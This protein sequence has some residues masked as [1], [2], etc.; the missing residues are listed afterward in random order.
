MNI[1]DILA[2]IEDLTAKGVYLIVA[3]FG[4]V[5][6]GD[7]DR[8]GYLEGSRLKAIRKLLNRRRISYHSSSAMTWKSM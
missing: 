2:R 6:V 4:T 8:A 1:L 3:T 7:F 5:T